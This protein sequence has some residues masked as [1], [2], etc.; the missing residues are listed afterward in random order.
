[1]N[2]SQSRPLKIISDNDDDNDN[3]NKPLF[4]EDRLKRNEKVMRRMQYL[5]GMA[6]IGGFLFGYDTGKRR[7]EKNLSWLG[8]ALHTYIGLPAPSSSHLISSN[9]ILSYNVIHSRIF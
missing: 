3:D 4:S 7:E 2:Q 8:F 5:T 1:M 6:A 9:I